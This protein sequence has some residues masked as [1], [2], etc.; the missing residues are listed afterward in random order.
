M[1]IIGKIREK[2]ILLV[3]IIGLALLAFIL[4]NYEKMSGESED[5]FGLGTIYGEKVNDK[6]FSEEADKFIQQDAQQAQQAQREYTEKE[7]DASE[8]KAWNNIVQTTVLQKEYDALGLDVS[9]AEFDA[10]LYGRDGFTVLPEIL[11][12]FSDATGRLDEKKL[13][14]TISK[15]QTSANA[16]DKKRWDDIKT[17]FK[18]RRKQEKYFSIIKQG[19]YVTKL[20]A[21]E[22]YKAQKEIKNISYVFNKYFDIKDASV[23]VTEEELHAY[24]EEHKNEKK[25]QNISDSR[26]VKYFDIM[27]S[28]S[29]KDSSEFNNRLDSIKKGFG[30]AVNDSLYV[31]KNSEL[32]FY[33]KKHNATFKPEDDAKAQKGMTYPK[34]MDTVFKTASVGQIV[35]PYQDNGSTR[36]AKVIDF[37]T[38]LCKV[39][40]ILIA[41]QKGED[42]KIAAAQKKADSIVNLLNKDNFAEYVMRFSEDP[43]SKD[44]GGVYEDFLDYEMVPEFSA[45]ATDKAIG[46]IGT[47][48]TDFGIHIIEVMD[49]KTVKFPV[50]A[51]IQQTLVPSENTIDKTESDVYNIL[52]KLDSKISA[53]SDLGKKITLFDTIVSKA[54]YMSRPLRI[55]TNK[56]MIYGFNTKPAEDKILKLAY[57]E[58]AEVGTLC[59]NP[60]KDKNRYV[61]AILASIRVKGIAEYNDVKDLVKSELIKETKAKRYI[62]AMM[63]KSLGSI[64]KKNGSQIMKADVTFAN[65]QITGAGYEPEVVGAI[66]SQLKDGQKT[67]P[68]KGE[69][70]VYVIKLNKTVKAPTTANYNV[71]K[72]QLLNTIKGS[73]MNQALQALMKKAD[74]IDNRRF[75]NAGI[76]REA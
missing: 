45:F 31:M 6:K 71:E 49:R 41:A 57:S 34:Y 13:E 15:M 74:V 35:G 72:E 65:P 42:K 27:V 70:G 43:G 76:R 17:S 3:V 64:A 73:I 22:E 1:A 23:K 50:L 39:R 67:L 14:T 20:E 68:L 48:K 10:Y 5:V 44:K 60:I 40:H 32:K 21:K 58:N 59:S 47:V 29:R 66:F 33:T 69:A 52:Y 7:K 37:N 56:P 28:P 26:E 46:T 8:D 53:E 61:I 16:E 18:E 25:F 38:K 55:E 30:T 11:R 63:N 51:L 62:A 54:G 36:I 19:V 9:E 24:F 75:V 2:S 12:D 4:G